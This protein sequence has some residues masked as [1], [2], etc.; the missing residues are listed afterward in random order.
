MKPQKSEEHEHWGRIFP[1]LQSARKR[2]DPAEGEQAVAK[3]AR[4]K[5]EADVEAHE[6][7]RLVAVKDADV[8]SPRTDAHLNFETPGPEQAEGT[9]YVHALYLREY[10]PDAGTRRFLRE[11]DGS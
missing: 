11:E 5:V 6:Y 4:R 8:H 10:D 7:G 9:G 2:M 3:E 1:I